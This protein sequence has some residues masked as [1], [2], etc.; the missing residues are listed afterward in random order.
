MYQLVMARV[1][2]G[3]TL[4]AQVSRRTL[5]RVGALAAATGGLLRPDS[6]SAAP[7]LIGRDRTALT[8]GVQSGDVTADSATLWTR[9][10]RP[11]RMLVEIGRRPDLLDARRVRGP[12][13][14]PDTDLTGKVRVNR[15]PAG[16]RLFYRVR[17]D[18]SEPITGS[19]RAA[20]RERSDIR[21]LWSADIVGQG[22]G[23]N[24]DVGGITI[25]EAMRARQPD[26]FLCSGDH[27][28]A[29]NPLTETVTLPD[30]RVWH[31]LVTP[32]KSKVAETLA[33]FRGQFAYNRLDANVRAFTAE[34]SQISQWDDHEVMNNWSPGQVLDDVRYT[35]RSVD[36][37]AAR[38]KRA[39]H[40]WLPVSAAPA[41]DCGRIY[42]KISYGPLLDVFV[43]DMRTFKD[44][45]SDNRYAD[46]TRGLLGP[47][48]RQW[49]I[50]ELTSSTATWKIIANDLP[51][52]AI[53]SAGPGL[54]E[55][56]AQDDHG[57]PLGRE[58]EF[59]EVLRTAHQRGVTGLVFLTAD[60][61]YSAAH[62]YDPAS[63][64]V[65]DFAPF[66]EFVSG[67][68]HAGGFGPNRLDR[69][70]GPEAVFVH[71]PPTPYYSPM[72]GFQH[73]GEVSIEGESA[74]LTVHLR[75]QTGQSLWSTTL[76]A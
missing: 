31:N 33:E 18:D 68:L 29:D 74:A 40:E 72:D 9:A 15:L 49:L 50:R 24:P 14:T 48:Q 73:F 41:D 76:T 39:F 47:A 6:A 57:V 66:W 5:L 32:E 58:L 62:R 67:P 75:D 28:Y 12:L 55:G 53:V 8:H 37:L 38:A 64:A 71:A 69:T 30:G 26:F 1:D 25:F 43:L 60:V 45:N 52:G 59:A 56:V 16:E 34:V 20:P 22:W 10:D 54:Y 2:N 17:V 61:H 4:M 65:A 36:V 13:L 35:E 21:F 44:P 70:F 51:L 23:I 3:E 63:A 11:G 46:P 7:A 19:L 42:R 27:I